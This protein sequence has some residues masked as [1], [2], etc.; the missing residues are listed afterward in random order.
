MCPGG[1][2]QFPAVSIRPLS[3]RSSDRR[4]YYFLIAPVARVPRERPHHV[5]DSSVNTGSPGVTELL[6]TVLIW[7]TLLSPDTRGQ[8]S[9]VLKVGRVVLLPSCSASIALQASL[10]H[11]VYCNDL[12]WIQDQQPGA[13]I[14]IR[15]TSDIWDTKGHNGSDRPPLSPHGQTPSPQTNC[16]VGRPNDADPGKRVQTHVNGQ[17]GQ[18]H[19]ADSGLI[20]HR[21]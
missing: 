11:A 6:I 20:H 21:Q 16:T 3:P 15:Q 14:Y 19:S 17:W 4:S 9:P 10:G 12:M 1:W 5:T 18:V 13:S 7:S 2:L 8:K